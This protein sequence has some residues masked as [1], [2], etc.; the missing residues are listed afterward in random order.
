MDINAPLRLLR[1]IIIVLMSM[2]VAPVLAQFGDPISHVA[3]SLPG[4]IGG[5]EIGSIYA[6]IMKSFIIGID[7]AG[8]MMIA[9]AGF[10]LTF[11]QGDDQLVKARKTIGYV[12]TALILMNLAVP[13]RDAFVAYQTNGANILKVEVVGLL[14]YFETLLAITAILFII[15]SG[16]RAVTAYGKEDGT[17]HLKQ[18]VIGV[19]SGIFLISVKTLIV[20][21]VIVDRTPSPLLA[22]IKTALLVVLGFIALIATV[23]LIWAGLLMIVNVGKDEQY[24][25]AKA[26]AGRVLIGLVVIL[27]SMAIVQFVISAGA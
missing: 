11:V 22:V 20:N 21:A 2:V 5:D 3:G 1:I 19:V 17:T 26:L 25:K 12:A 16:I 8:V 24:T 6:S 13:M 18:A 10:T 23:V 14:S 27:V 7:V 4:G 15:I 9:R